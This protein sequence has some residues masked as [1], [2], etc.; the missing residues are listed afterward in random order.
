M[1]VLHHCD[2]AAWMQFCL[3]HPL[4]DP[5]LQFEALWSTDSKGRKE[6]MYGEPWT[7]IT[8]RLHATRAP[9]LFA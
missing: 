8:A 4:A 6:R 7:V 2:V 1:Q 9:L 3:E 5:H